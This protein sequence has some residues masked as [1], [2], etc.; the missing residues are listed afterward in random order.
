MV[1]PRPPDAAN[2]DTDLRIDATDR[3]VGLRARGRRHATSP[4]SSFTRTGFFG[5]LDLLYGLCGPY[6][7]IGLHPHALAVDVPLL[8]VPSATQECAGSRGLI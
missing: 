4:V 1:N 3:I 7:P 5:G 6:E 2:P 8:R